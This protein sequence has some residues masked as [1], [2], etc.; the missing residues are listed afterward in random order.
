MRQTF[1]FI[2]SLFRNST[3]KDAGTKMMKDN[4][5]DLTPFNALPRCRVEMVG[6]AVVTGFAVTFDVL[7]KRTAL[8]ISHIYCSKGTMWMLQI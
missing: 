1:F 5:R 4:L 8:Q 7:S 3:I 2:M 6:V